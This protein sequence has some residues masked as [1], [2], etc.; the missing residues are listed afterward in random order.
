LQDDPQQ[1]EK[2]D[3]TRLPTRFDHTGDGLKNE[4]L[5]LATDRDIV[6]HVGNDLY[7]GPVPVNKER[8]DRDEQDHQ[9]KQREERIEGKRSRPL[10]PVNPEKTFD[11]E[12][13]Y[14]PGPAGLL[15]KPARSIHLAPSRPFMPGLPHHLGQNVR[16]DPQD[17]LSLPI[18][19]RVLR[20]GDCRCCLRFE[21]SLNHNQE[22]VY[23]GRVSSGNFS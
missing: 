8:G 22:K 4:T 13:Q 5:H 6:F 17:K 7:P 19:D 12:R 11:G 23:I 1:D 16:Q 2:C 21:T 15:V 14:R 20:L 3:H 10:R 9:G 18:E